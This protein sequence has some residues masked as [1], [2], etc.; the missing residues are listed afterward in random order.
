MTFGPDGVAPVA[1]PALYG[2]LEVVLH[3]YHSPIRNLHHS[4]MRFLRRTPNH[5]NYRLQDKVPLQ[6]RRIKLR[7][8]SL[9]DSF[10]KVLESSGLESMWA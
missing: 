1:I 9:P 6:S 4:L 8:L 10:E 5:K 7:G 2:S 3:R